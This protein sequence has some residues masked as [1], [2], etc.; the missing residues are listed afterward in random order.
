MIVKL[1]FM[2]IESPVV[3]IKK[4]SVWILSFVLFFFPVLFLVNTTDPFL[5]PKQVFLILAS[6]VLLFLWCITA[7]YEKKIVLRTSP[8]TLPAGLFTLAVLISAFLSRNM[9]DSVALAIPVAAAF[10][11]YFVGINSISHKIGR[12][13]V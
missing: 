12:A 10:V 1:N 2:S 3:I 11:L 8:F 4:I 9:Y 13:H 6:T 5:L 7:V